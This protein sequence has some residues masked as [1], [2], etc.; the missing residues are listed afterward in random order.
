MNVPGTEIYA[1]GTERFSPTGQ[2]SIYP[3]RIVVS[4]AQ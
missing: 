1:S 4:I 3:K 2:G